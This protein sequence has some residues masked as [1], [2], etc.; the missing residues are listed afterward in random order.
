MIFYISD[1]TTLAMTDLLRLFNAVKLVL[2][3]NL[4]FAFDL[5]AN[6]ERTRDCLAVTSAG[7]KFAKKQIECKLFS[8]THINFSRYF[9][10]LIIIII[11]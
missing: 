10:Q 6:T 2:F 3:S 7:S 5:A 4:P 9:N 11:A 1:E 8:I